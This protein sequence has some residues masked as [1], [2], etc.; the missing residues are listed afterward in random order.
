MPNMFLDA[1]KLRCVLEYFWFAH[2]SDSEIVNCLHLLLLHTV[3]LP[4]YFASMQGLFMILRFDLIIVDEIIAIEALLHE[5][6][7]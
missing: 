1:S 2:W 5:I 6:P 7:T 4:E 3:A